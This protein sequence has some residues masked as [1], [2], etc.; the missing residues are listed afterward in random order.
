MQAPKSWVDYYVKKFG[1]EKPYLG[2]KGYFPN[3]YPNATYAAMISY[4]DERVGQLVGK[5]KEEGIYENTILIFTSDNGSPA[6]AGDP[7][8]HGKA[9]QVPGS[10]ITM[11]DHNPN[12]PLRGMKTEIHEGGHRVPFIV[13]WPGQF[14][15]NK[16]SDETIEAY[17]FDYCI[18]GLF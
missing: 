4:L 2:D 12:A 13:K 6:R 17:V 11:F 18:S 1:D 3:R 14:P 9:F 5:L 16:V 15:A 8:L 10:T 7:H